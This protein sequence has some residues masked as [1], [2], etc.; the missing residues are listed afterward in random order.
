[1]L[2]GLYDTLLSVGPM[3]PDMTGMEVPAQ[4][5]PMLDVQIVARTR[6]PFRCFGNVLV[7]PTASIDDIG[8]VDAVIVCDLFSPIHVAPRGLYATESRWLRELHGANAL[9][10]SVCS[11]SL[12]LAESGVLDGRTCAGHWAYAELYRSA[13]PRVRFLPD[14]V[15]DLESLGDGIVTAG[16]VTSWQELALFLIARFCGTEQATQTAK[17]YLLGDHGSGQLPF[18]AMTRR[19]ASGDAVVRDVVGW[20]SEHYAISDPVRAMVERSGLLA[21]TFARRFQGATGR[22][23]IEFVHGLRVEEARRLLETGDGSIDDV[24]YE[25]GYEDP[26]FF[27]RLF[28]RT[29]GLSPAAYRRR[30][31]SLAALG[32]G[33]APGGDRTP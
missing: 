28:K 18:T 25:V 5:E 31:A 3:W 11:G 21:R 16:G 1:V 15:L 6:E 10:G 26:T 23:P 33:G 19:P 29:T 8:E 32:V 2:Y 14:K 12:L 24:G 20:I 27:R 30:Y 22:R 17:V 7:E 13:Y 4:P 9:V